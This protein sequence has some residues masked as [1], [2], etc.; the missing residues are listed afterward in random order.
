MERQN[1]RM[2]AVGAIVS[3]LAVVLLYISCVLPTLQLTVV[4]VAGVLSAAVL[5]ECGPGRAALVYLCVSALSLLLLPDKSSA[6]FYVL[7]FG[8]YPIVKY[9]LERIRN[10]VFCWCAK[11][12]SGNLC[13]GALA[14]LLA[15][16]FPEWRFEYPLWIVWLLGN[17]VFVLFDLALTKLIAYYQFRIRPKIMR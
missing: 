6:V 8:H 9:E 17:A 16:F 4:A 1:S 5:I 10:P 12:A 3:A 2:L 7:F 13:I 11:L 14:L 15:I